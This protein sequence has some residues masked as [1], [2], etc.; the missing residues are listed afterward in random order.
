MRL[1]Y[2]RNTGLRKISAQICAFYGLLQNAKGWFKKHNG[3]S[4]FTEE[5]PFYW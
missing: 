2:R 1:A 3:L 4:P 5:S